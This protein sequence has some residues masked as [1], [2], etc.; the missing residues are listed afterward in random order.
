MFQIR[1]H[2]ILAWAVSL[3]LFLTACGANSQNEAAIATAVAQ[4][5][6][7]GASSAPLPVLQTNTPEPSLPTLLPTLT[8]GFTPTA[9]STLSSAPS[10]PNC[11]HANL[12]G[13]Y[14][15][16]GTVYKPD[17]DF[18]KT[19]T[20]KNEGTCTWDSTYRLIFWSGDALGGATYYNLPEIV[21]PGDDIPITINLKAPSAEGTYT[22]YWRLQT[23]W[24][25]VFGVGQ[26]SQ[27]FYANIVVNK[28]PQRE[29]GIVD[30][31]YQIVREPAEGCPVNVLYTVYA[32]ITTSGPLDLSYYWEQKDGNESAV[33]ELSFAAAGSKTVSRSWM[34]GRGDSPN[35]RWMQIIV[36]MPEY[37]EFP[38][39]TWP[40]NCP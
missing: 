30:L 13:E 6:E 39:A 32:T 7:A 26:Y 3:S 27:A 20:I 31:E 24:N 9:E 37:T 29:Y 11:I 15:P 36:L 5:V 19:W 17:T 21:A 23:P 4:T 40:N 18:T 34:V 2:N 1:T 38:K 33:K 14:P 12:V 8:P 10:D 16:D 35:E 25:A 28:R 22:G